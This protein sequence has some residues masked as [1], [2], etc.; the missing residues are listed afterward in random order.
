[1]L[2]AYPMELT[3]LCCHTTAYRIWLKSDLPGSV[4]RAQLVNSFEV[5]RCLV[6]I[7]GQCAH[8]QAGAHVCSCQSL[9]HVD[10]QQ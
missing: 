3:K 1:M 10:P 2:Q 8:F 4:L 6:R 9:L 5:L 7:K